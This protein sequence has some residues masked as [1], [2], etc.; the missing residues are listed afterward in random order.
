[1]IGGDG[2]EEWSVSRRLGRSSALRHRTGFSYLAG[3]NKNVS[4]L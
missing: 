1:M 4:F 3:V 2:E